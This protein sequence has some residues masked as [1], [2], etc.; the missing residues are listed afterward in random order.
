MEF[1]ALAEIWTE[2]K[3]RGIV[4]EPRGSG[5]SLLT[6]DAAKHPVVLDLGP[7]RPGP[8]VAFAVPTPPDKSAAVLEAVL[9][10]LRLAPLYL[11][12]VTR[13]RNI[14]DV[15][16]F[17][18]AGNEAWQEVD[19]QAS[20]ELNSRDALVCEMRD[21]HTLRE[22]VRVLLQDGDHAEDGLSQALA[23]V[24]TGQPLVAHVTPGRPVRLV[25]GNSLV[26]EQARDAARH[27]LE[28]A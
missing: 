18:L 7:E 10:K 19:S 1:V 14:L 13:W 28:R 26:A 11:V 17:G 21:L 22:L 6:L 24:A 2:L 20:V 12:P 8:G 15:V 5:D 16:A 4:E 3:G 9:H 23:I 25:V 27:F